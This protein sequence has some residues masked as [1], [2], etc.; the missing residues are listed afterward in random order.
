MQHYQGVQPLINEILL[1][2]LQF[3]CESQE[4]ML[5]T[6]CQIVDIP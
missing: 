2:Q 4:N 3:I 6:S 1:K 5:D